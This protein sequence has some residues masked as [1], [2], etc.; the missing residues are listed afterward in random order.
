MITTKTLTR[1]STKLAA[2][3]VL[4]G[5]AFGISACTDNDDTKLESA[6][7][8][9]ETQK[10]VTLEESPLTEEER[11]EYL[12]DGY[13]SSNEDIK[14]V[15]SIVKIIS[16][17]DDSGTPEVMVNELRYELDYEKFDNSKLEQLLS[18]FEND[19]W[20]ILPEKIDAGDGGYYIIG[21]KGT[22]YTFRLVD[23]NKDMATI[24]I[25]GVEK[26]AE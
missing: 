3:L 18:A 2:V 8:I 12:I 4:G 24:F 9:D 15:D 1:T 7:T 23:N 13:H 20:G 6:V 19:G 25:A 17:V 5:L 14:D 10:P 26:N 21:H 22:E 11:A 16:T